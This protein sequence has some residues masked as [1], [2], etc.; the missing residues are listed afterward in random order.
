M[1]TSFGYFKEKDDDRRVALNM[2]KSLKK[3][4]RLIMELMGKER[5]ARIFQE[6]GWNEIGNRII[7]EERKM[8]EDWSM[9]SN[10]WIVMDKSG[11]HEFKL[12]HRIYSAVELGDVLRECGFTITGVYGGLS[13]E[14]YGP[15]ALRLVMVAKKGKR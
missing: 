2:Y 8:N 11:Q 14:P 3:G 12:T 13:G 10:R 5:L 7:L 6:R 4:G 9:I 15:N 1:F